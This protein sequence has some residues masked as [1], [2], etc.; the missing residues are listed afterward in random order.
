[1][2]LSGCAVQQPTAEFCGD[3]QEAWNNFVRIRDSGAESTVV[4][5]A[6]DDLAA[7]WEDLTDRDDA[8]DDVT[9]WVPQVSAAFAE[10][11]NATSE[12]ERHKAQTNW[13]NS[14]GYVAL[15]C[16]KAGHPLDFQG[17]EEPIKP[18]SR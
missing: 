2:L 12:S 13:N 8:P 9:E 3:Y 18:P 10:A 1:M 5:S 11:W 7:A 14:N 15:R 4:L 16:E 6:R 17:L